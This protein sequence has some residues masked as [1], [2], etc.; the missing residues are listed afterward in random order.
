MNNIVDAYS[1]M[2]TK[3]KKKFLA[4]LDNKQSLAMYDILKM[5]KHKITPALWVEQ[6]IGDTLWDMQGVILN[7][8][9]KS[10]RISVRSCHGAGKSF[11]AARAALWFLNT[12]EDSIVVTTAPTF[13]Q[14]KKILWKE[15]RA[16]HKKSVVPLK[17]NCLTTELNISPEWFAFG[18]STKEPDAFQGL[19]SKYILLIFDEA[20]G[21]EADLHVSAEGILSN[22]NAFKLS[23]GNPTDPASPFAADFRDPDVRKITISAFDTPNF[24]AF[25][26][27]PADI[28]KGTW[29]QKITGPLPYAALV[30]PHWVARA[31]RKWGPESPMYQ[32]RVLAQ[33]PEQGTDTLI[34]LSWIDRAAQKDIP[35]K[36][37]PVLGV[38]CAYFGDDKNKVCKRN[39][40]RLRIVDTWGGQD[41][42]AS[43]GRVIRNYKD[44]TPRASHI[45][46]DVIG[47]GA[48]VVDRVIEEKCPG[49]R[50]NVAESAYD[51]EQFKNK[52][53]EL[54]WELRLL[55]QDNKVDLDIHDEDLQAQLSSLKFKYTG[56]GQIQIEAKDEMKKRV[57]HSPDDA[58][59]AMLSLD[60]APTVVVAGDALS[61]DTNQ[62]KWRK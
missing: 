6:N 18:F 10:R 43:A 28:A 16:A 51:S 13:R 23:I 26:I 48:G 11:T 41:T 34:P 29:E 1:Q 60:N 32:A 9:I 30:S 38:D 47:Y 15:I 24:T 56:K 52:R 46:V 42:Q 44:M 59:A 54:Y 3:D 57:G 21:I 7:S 33:F 36:G 55:F 22:E 50:V 27:K 61:M 5:A 31:Y 8:F 20:S 58:D 49:V 35:E 37:V 4:Q 19:H 14:V 2:N 40:G 62:S 39:G 45:N 12:F 53:A 25:N 17:G